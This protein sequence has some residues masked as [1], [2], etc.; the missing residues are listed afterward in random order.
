MIWIFLFLPAAYTY[1]AGFIWLDCVTAWS[2]FLYDFLPSGPDGGL[3][4]EDVILVTILAVVVSVLLIAYV[5]VRA[6]DRLLTH[7]GWLGTWV[8]TM[9]VR[10]LT[11]TTK[12]KGMRAR[13]VRWL[14]AR[15]GTGRKITRV[16]TIARKARG[17]GPAR[18]T[19]KPAPGLQ[20][21]NDDR[22]FEW[23]AA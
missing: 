1:W 18:R 14:W 12:E 3:S 13:T 17:E 15:V 10:M 21:A 7:T 22:A 19:R 2:A 6:I 23:R 20:A 4:L 8:G 9:A 11:M 16:S 5:V